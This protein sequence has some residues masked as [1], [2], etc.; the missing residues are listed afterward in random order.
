MP[1]CAL[2]NRY[3]DAGPECGT[4]SSQL[5]SLL[6][7]VLEFLE[8]FDHQTQP[9]CWFWKVLLMVLAPSSFSLQIA[10]V[11]QLSSRKYSYL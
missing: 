9:K 3:R 7:A 8:V 1:I 5:Q 6:A 11:A 4:W 2:S 10:L